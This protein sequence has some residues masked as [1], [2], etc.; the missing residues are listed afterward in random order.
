M[1]TELVRHS[2][3]TSGTG[4]VVAAIAQTGLGT[5]GQGLR[6]TELQ[7]N[8]AA[9]GDWGPLSGGNIAVLYW[10]AGCGDRRAAIHLRTCFNRSVLTIVCRIALGIRIPLVSSVTPPCLSNV[11]CYQV[12]E[13]GLDR[14]P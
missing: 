6:A 5:K 10:V 3:G 11:A 4:A 1:R 2:N 7:G 13:A 8:A 12:M 14:A 9:E